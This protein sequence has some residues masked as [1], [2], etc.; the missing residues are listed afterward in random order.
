M[1]DYFNAYFF[2]FCYFLKRGFMKPRLARTDYVV[3]TP[4]IPDIPDTAS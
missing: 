3:R 2:V 4:W 1:L